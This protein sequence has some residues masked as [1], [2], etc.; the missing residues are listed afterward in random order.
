MTQVLVFRSGDGRYAVPVEHC[1]EV[2]PATEVTPLPTLAEDVV[3]VL[4][5]RDRTLSV[6]AP[7]GPGGTHVV[8]LDTGA[9]PFGLL[10]DSVLGVERFDAGGVG[11]AP[12]GQR[13]PLVGGT[14]ASAGGEL[15]FLVDVGAVERWLCR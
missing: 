10:V 12:R 5:W 15:L 14:A 8:V 11:D 3:G 6:I 9:E 1:R 4:R 2:R 13:H 7:L